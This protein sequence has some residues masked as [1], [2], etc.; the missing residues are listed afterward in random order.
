M[1]KAF[2]FL[3]AGL[4]LTLCAVQASAQYYGPGGRTVTAPQMYEPWRNIYYEQMATRAYNVVAPPF[5]IKKY[6]VPGPPGQ[7]PPQQMVPYGY[8]PVPQGYYPYY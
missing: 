4:I 6:Y 2:L 8:P 1:K 5:R 3:L 7:L